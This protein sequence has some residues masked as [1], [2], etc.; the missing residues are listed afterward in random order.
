MVY[1]IN[2][3]SSCWFCFIREAFENAFSPWLHPF[4]FTFNFIHNFS[5]V[6][7]FDIHEVFDKT[8]RE[9]LDFSSTDDT[10]MRSAIFKRNFQRLPSAPATYNSMGTRK[11]PYTSLWMEAHYTASFYGNN[12]DIILLSFVCLP[13]SIQL[14]ESINYVRYF[15]RF[16]RP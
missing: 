11:S 9:V 5:N 6:F 15:G 8:S 16:Y 3:H 13:C 2:K 12:T 10:A 14:E 7:P 4:L 1:K